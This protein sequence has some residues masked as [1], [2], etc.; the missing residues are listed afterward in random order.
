MN[1]VGINLPNN[2]NNFINLHI[3]NLTNVSNF[4]G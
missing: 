1:S 4:K 2:Y 3:F